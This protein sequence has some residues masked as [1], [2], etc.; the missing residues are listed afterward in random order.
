MTPIN[1]MD[2]LFDGSNSHELC[3]ACRGTGRVFEGEI[4]RFCE[5]KES[6]MDNQ[7]VVQIGIEPTTVGNLIQWL[8][9]I[10]P[11][12]EIWIFRQRDGDNEVVPFNPSIHIDHDKNWGHDPF[13]PENCKT[14]L[15]IDA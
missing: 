6:E 13:V 8:S 9:A 7:N 11:G 3:A 1:K 2:K 12:R 10:A 14:R 4:C 5:N 15:V